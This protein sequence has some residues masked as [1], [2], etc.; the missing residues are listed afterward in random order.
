MS[1]KYIITFKQTATDEQIEQ[2]KEKAAA[3][4]EVTKSFTLLKGFAATLDAN[5]FSQFSSF[6]AENDSIIETIEPD[7]IVTTQ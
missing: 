2:W 5:T 4:G 3:G 6:A 1:G 7:G